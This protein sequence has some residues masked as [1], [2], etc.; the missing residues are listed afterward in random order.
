MRKWSNST[1]VT[2]LL[3]VLLILWGIFRAVAYGRMVHVVSH[4]APTRVSV[5]AVRKLVKQ[6]K[7]ARVFKD[8]TNLAK[9]QAIRVCQLLAA[10]RGI[11]EIEG[12][13][14]AM[15]EAAAGALVEFLSDLELPVRAAAADALGRMGKP[16]A[17]P[18]LEVA[19]NSPDKDVRTNATKALVAI[20]AVAVP[21]MVE[22]VKSGKPTM[23]VGAATA[24][25]RLQT[26][27]AIS[28]LIGALS[29]KETEVRL[30]C[31]DA[32]VAIGEPSVEPLVAA[33]TNTSPLTRR[34]AA[35]ALGEIRDPRGAEPLMVCVS[36]ENRLV[37]LAATYA[38]GKVGQ[39]VATEL[40]IRTLGDADREMR[41]GAAVSLGQIAD[42]RAVPRLVALLEDPIEAVRE[43]AAAALG[44]IQPRDPATLAAIEALSRS[45]NEGTRAAAVFGL[46]QIGDPSSVAAVAVRLSPAT[47]PSAKIRR[48]AATAL[49]RI[50]APAAIPH[51]LAALSDPD[52]RVNYFAQEALAEIGAPAVPALI[53]VFRQHQALRSR[54]A[55][56]SLA[57]MEPR[58]VAAL[59]AALR[60]PDAQVR[61]GAAQTLGD[62]ADEE[63]LTLLRTVCLNDPDEAVSYTAKR[64]LET[65]GG[66]A[67]TESPASPTAQT[68]PPGAPAA[69]GGETSP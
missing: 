20:G 29:A 35:E 6:R 67:A 60:S 30:A 62:I 37:R 33:L 11:V 5:E 46:G 38:L 17:R 8:R 44:R 24:L 25:G 45:G 56:K 63:S 69:E 55:R 14:L 2:L 39:P 50:G 52:W 10:D 12:H 1:K 7:L 19:L 23:K 22:A 68:T 54:Y 61:L 64:V 47:E 57:Q 28:A 18:L 32:L 53:E 34:H 42:P 58:P 15:A 4:Q 40:L 65:R 26:P 36:D 59:A 31:R 66:G 41:E 16:A 49:G 48:R 21:E 13:H 43:Q 27:R 9:Y 51:L 3:V